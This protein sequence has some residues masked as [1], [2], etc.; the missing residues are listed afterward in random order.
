MLV[1]LSLKSSGQRGRWN[2][3]RLGRGRAVAVR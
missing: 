2:V 3:E 1:N